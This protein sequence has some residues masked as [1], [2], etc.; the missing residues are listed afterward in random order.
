MSQNL[1]IKSVNLGHK[2]VPFEE[3][4]DQEVGL[5]INHPNLFPV[6]YEYEKPKSNVLY[7]LEPLKQGQDYYYIDCCGRVTHSNWGY[8]SVFNLNN[9][10][11]TK[12]NAKKQ[13]DRNQLLADIQRFADENNEKIEWWSL[14]ETKW[15]IA[16]DWQEKEWIL[17]DT[18][19][20][21]YPNQTYFS[22]S[23][24]GLEA[25]EKFKDRLD[26]LID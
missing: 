5:I 10:F 13:A 25:L 8:E 26:I 17:Q 9:V 2:I 18:D 23:D 7:E 1:K 15:F 6:E 11:L 4:S 21:F 16:Y 3:L 14:E 24:R 19:Q 12:E 22:S 20:Y